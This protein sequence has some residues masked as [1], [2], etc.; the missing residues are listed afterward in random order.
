MK[1]GWVYLV[2]LAV[3]AA[4]GGLIYSVRTS[5]IPDE[6]TGYV[7]ALPKL[8]DPVARQISYEASGPE[9]TSVT[10]SYL[11]EDIRSRDLTAVLPWTQSLK[12]S[13][14]AFMAAL[15]VQSP[16]SRIGCRIT[17]DGVV[18]DEQV[19]KSEAGTVSCRVQI[20]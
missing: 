19:S 18:R 3:V 15:I 20:A 8:G 4:A 13:A 17:V 10:V 5:P 2:V 16:T 7:L 1:T 14:G 11:G 12:T 6:T 9:G